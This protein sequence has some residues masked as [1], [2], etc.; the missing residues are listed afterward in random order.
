MFLTH[1]DQMVGIEWSREHL[2]DIKFGPGSSSP[3]VPFDQWFP[4]S[5]V[6]YPTGI[7]ELKTFDG[8]LSEFSIPIKTRERQLSITFF[9]DFEHVLLDWFT[10]WMNS[11]F[12]NTMASTSSEY[13]TPSYVQ[14][15]DQVTKQVF[16][17]R[18]NSQRK[19]IT[20]N[21]GNVYIDSFKVFPTDVIGFKG[22]SDA[23]PNVYTVKFV[24]A[25]IIKQNYVSNMI[26]QGKVTQKQI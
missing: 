16:I 3:P 23:K 13:L 14:T 1:V 10:W 9:D 2:W 22:G 19:E 24:I 5:D 6:S 21:S 7:V 8:P 11:M 26:K 4:A 15:L 12:G 18:L 17:S 20:L 25:A